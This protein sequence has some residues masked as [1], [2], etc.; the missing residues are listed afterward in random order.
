M[1]VRP[2]KCSV[3]PSIVRDCSTRI[4]NQHYINSHLLRL[5]TNGSQSIPGTSPSTVTAPSR[6]GWEMARPTAHRAYPTPSS[7]TI[8]SSPLT[9]P[10][11]RPMTGVRLMIL[12]VCKSSSLHSELIDMESLHP[13]KPS[14]IVEVESLEEEHKLLE[15]PVLDMV[16]TMG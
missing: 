9:S 7:S 5:L 10:S 2:N 1:Q 3:M 15:L 11:L 6:Q 16:P 13:L 14:P 12:A 8:T 4:H